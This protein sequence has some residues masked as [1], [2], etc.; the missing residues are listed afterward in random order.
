MKFK[1]IKQKKALLSIL[2]IAFM[3]RFIGISWGLPFH[4]HPDEW[5]MAA[6]VSRLSWENMLNPNFFAYG[7]F[8]LYLSIFSAKAYGLLP[9]VKDTSVSIGEAIFFLRFWSAVAGGASVYFVYLISKRLLTTNY[10][11]LAALLAAFT[12]GLIQASHF[13]T[14][15]SL[16]SFFFLLLVYLSF[17]ILKEDSLK[18]YFFA[19]AV[20][21]LALGTKISSLL[22]AAPVFLSAFINIYFSFLKKN[23][24]KLINQVTFLLFFMIISVLFFVLFSPYVLLEFEE[25]RRILTYETQVALGQIPVF[26]T[27]QFI[28][29]K[30]VIYQITKIFPFALGPVIFFLGFTGIIYLFILL[31]RSMVL[32]KITLKRRELFVFFVSFFVFF[33]YQS[34]LFCKWTRFMSPIFPFFAIFSALT[35]QKVAQKV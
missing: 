19:G 8:P 24:V 4:F 30:P 11:L 3:L 26:Y 16:Q 10:S 27:R 7:Q 2:L 1:K 18:H 23:W 17:K 28:E 32:K 35:L 14:T 33:L 12:P 13:G 15:E 22:F 5:N 21:G 9:W 25:T 34:F 20:L 6:A 29:T 31:A